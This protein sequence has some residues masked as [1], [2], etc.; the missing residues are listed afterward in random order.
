MTNKKEGAVQVLS[1]RTRKAGKKLLAM[2]KSKKLQRKFKNTQQML[3]TRSYRMGNSLKINPYDLLGFQFRHFVNPDLI[4]TNG[5]ITISNPI[6]S[7]SGSIVMLFKSKDT[8]HQYVLKV[9][10]MNS[11][12]V[13][14]PGREINFPELESEIY[15]VV[16]RLVQKNI[17]PHTFTFVN[18]FLNIR[19]EYLPDNN[20]FKY[21]GLDTNMPYLSVMLNET[22]SANAGLKTLSKFIL[23]ELVKFTLVEKLK[24][25]YNILFQIIYTLEVFNRVGIMHNDLHT[26]NVFIIMKNNSFK[27]PNYKKTFRK[28]RFK[29]GNG[30]QYS[31]NLENIGFDVRIYDY[32]RSYKFNKPGTEFPEILKTNNMIIYRDF[33]Q[34]HHTQNPYFD[35]YKILC[36]LYHNYIGILPGTFLTLIHDFFIKHSLLNSGIVGTKD[37]LSA[38]APYDIRDY[39][40][41]N[42][43]PVGH[44]K[45]TEEILINLTTDFFIGEYLSGKEAQVP[46][47]ETYDMDGIN[48]NIHA[49]D[50][51]R[52]IIRES[53]K[54]PGKSRSRRVSMGGPIRKT[55]RRPSGRRQSVARINVQ[56]KK[57]KRK[58]K[59]NSTNSNLLRSSEIEAGL[60][61][62]SNKVFKSASDVMVDEFGRMDN[63]NGRYFNQQE[64]FE[65]GAEAFY[66]LPQPNSNN[67]FV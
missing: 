44:M 39:F 40:L 19:R 23:N 21:E 57:K 56:K 11:E 59:V 46:V 18:N 43:Q 65:K 66:G 2:R 14:K 35:T 48:I 55:A 29:A 24:I 54:I 45:T 58:G 6:D 32:D 26:G 49:R 8:D 61:M 67:P 47:I 51:R 60:E 31:I 42:S 13:I 4:D 15:E 3:N 28:Y 10:G 53:S 27:Q 37:Y 5:G 50:K 63:N 64:K 25:M 7:A 41:I 62:G 34:Y 52:A 12:D 16:T 9:T 20:Y 33:N 36:N 38:S 1:P 22:S 17:T 30:T